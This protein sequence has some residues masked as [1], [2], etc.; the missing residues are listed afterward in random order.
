MRSWPELR[1]D[2][3]RKLANE[4]EFYSCLEEPED[5]IWTMGKGQTSWNLSDYL[6]SFSPKVWSCSALHKVRTY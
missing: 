2:K 3:E 5:M 6:S 1:P 4:V